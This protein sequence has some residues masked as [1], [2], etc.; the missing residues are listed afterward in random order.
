MGARAVDR[1]IGQIEGIAE[2]VRRRLQGYEGCVI[3]HFRRG[4][5]ERIE[6]VVSRAPGL[7]VETFTHG[8]E[9]DDEMRGQTGSVTVPCESG[10][11]RKPR[12][13][14]FEPF[15]ALPR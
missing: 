14:V 2:Y 4:T 10:R 8:P 1:S 7:S 6:Y 13:R 15:D 5:C 11:F 12:Y 3:F 9:I